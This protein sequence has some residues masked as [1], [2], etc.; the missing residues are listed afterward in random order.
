MLESI[1]YRQTRSLSKR[2]Y[3]LYY[4]MDF[5]SMAAKKKTEPMLW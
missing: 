2:N 3:V 4:W 5:L 1:N